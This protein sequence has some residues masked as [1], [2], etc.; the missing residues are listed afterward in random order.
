MITGI[1]YVG[2]PTTDLKKARDFYEGILG[3]IPSDEFPVKEDSQYIEYNI[4]SGTLA[5]GCMGEWK[6]SKDGP[7]I[8]FE[9]DDFDGT[10]QMLKD[11]NVEFRMEAQA[12]PNCSMA[13]VRDPDGNQV[14]IH[15]H[16]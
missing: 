1:A 3:L 8:A 12:W 6:P 16:K 10:I 11:K 13:I 9:V 4:G 2:Y 5:L 14:V 15:H 7:C